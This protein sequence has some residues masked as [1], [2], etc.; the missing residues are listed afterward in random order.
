MSVAL[1]TLSFIYYFVFIYF[2][3]LPSLIKKRCT[4]IWHIAPYSILLHPMDCTVRERESKIPN[5]P[6][7][8]L[9]RM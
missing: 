6:A 8:V 2:E 5:I 3:M 4:K 7:L 9:W 1:Y